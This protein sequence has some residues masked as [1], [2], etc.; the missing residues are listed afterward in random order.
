VSRC[1]PPTTW[2]RRVVELIAFAALATPA[3]ASSAPR[4]ARPKPYVSPT[5]TV[6]PGTTTFTGTGSTYTVAVTVKLCST[7]SADINDAATSFTLDGSAVSLTNT[8]TA[9]PGCT[10]SRTYTGNV[11]LPQ[12]NEGVHQFWAQTED[13]NG[14]A[15]FKSA[16]YTYHWPGWVAPHYAVRV[17]PTVHTEDVATGTNRTATFTVTN[18]G[19]R[20]AS[21]ALTYRCS[22]GATCTGTSTSPVTLDTITRSVTATVYFTAVA[23]NDTGSVALVAK[24]TGTGL[25]ADADSASMD[26]M[27]PDSVPNRSPGVVIAGAGDVI[28]RDRCLTIAVADAAAYECGDLRLVHALPTVTT[29]GKARTPIL[30]YNSAHAIGNGVV[31][32][33]ITPVTS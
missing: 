5:V 21:Y 29:R 32:A 20:S 3:A 26:I 4:V 31:A 24:N 9:V 13:M 11:V 12:T 33:D 15:A 14:W 25:S 28:A 2:P 22:G 6:T 17:T 23:L 18:L 16:A 19:S 27:I 8:H 10:F 7:N 30:L 1:L